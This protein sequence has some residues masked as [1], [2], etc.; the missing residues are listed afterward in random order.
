MAAICAIGDGANDVAM[1]RAADVGIGVVGKEGRE[2]AN[3]ADFGLAKFE[4]LQDLLLIHGRYN[5]YRSSKV[6][7]AAPSSLIP[8]GAR[9]ICFVPCRLFLLFSTKIS[10]TFSS[11]FCS[12]FGLGCQVHCHHALG[13]QLITSMTCLQSVAVLW[14][15]KYFGP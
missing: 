7:G 15:D 6:R 9:K 11:S 14:Q 5:S 2:A 13:C 8:C 1:I 12:S 10:L 3:C 4:F